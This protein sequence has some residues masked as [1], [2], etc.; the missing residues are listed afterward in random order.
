MPD[1]KKGLQMSNMKED[2]R[3]LLVY[4]F[5]L[6]SKFPESCA[7]VTLYRWCRGVPLPKGGEE[8]VPGHHGS[9]FLP[10]RPAHP[11][12]QENLVRSHG[13]GKH[14]HTHYTVKF[15]LHTLMSSFL[16]RTFQAGFLFHKNK[17]VA[18]QIVSFLVLKGQCH[19]HCFQTETVG[20][21]V[22]LMCRNRF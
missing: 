5:L 16:W 12:T 3:A 10:H 14:T 2:E 8:W 4:I 19:E 20:W 11:R 9:G 22:L 1:P 7:T 15:T 6:V 18:K 13:G 17:N 21:Q